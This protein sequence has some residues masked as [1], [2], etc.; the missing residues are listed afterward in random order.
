MKK[1]SLNYNEFMFFG[2]KSDA[3][4]LIRTMKFRRIEKGY[5]QRDLATITN[6][7]QSAIARMEQLKII[8]RLDTII[9]IARALDLQLTFKR[10]ETGWH[11][12]TTDKK[13]D[14]E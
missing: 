2:I 5:S 13:D 10:I 11:K 9:L 3:K 14:L 6:V 1:E 7:K 12:F 8:P 4:N